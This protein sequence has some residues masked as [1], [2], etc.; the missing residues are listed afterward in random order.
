MNVLI[1]S[2]TAFDNANIQIIFGKIK[3]AAVRL[4]VKI[5]YL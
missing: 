3:L 1:E 4:Y 2:S 5:C